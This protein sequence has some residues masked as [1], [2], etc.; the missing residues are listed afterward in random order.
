MKNKRTVNGFTFEWN[1]DNGF[2]ECRGA[3]C[4]DNEHDETPEPALW[5]AAKQLVSILN[6]EGH[7]AD[8]DYSEKGWVEVSV[9]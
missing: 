3:V 1:E 4:Y 9:D 2:Y 8:R 6:E 5:K 7:E